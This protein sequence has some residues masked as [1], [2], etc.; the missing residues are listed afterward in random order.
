MSR[1]IRRA[2]GRYHPRYIPLRGG[3]ELCSHHTVASPDF[4]RKAHS[5]YVMPRWGGGGGG[6]GIFCTNFYFELSWKAATVVRMYLLPIS[7]FHSCCLTGFFTPIQ[8][9]RECVRS[10]YPVMNFCL[11]G[12][13]TSLTISLRDS[14]TDYGLCGFSGNRVCHPLYGQRHP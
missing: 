5:M 9:H 13:N 12:I 8:A 2:P 4:V 1:L 3:R 11:R 7:N 14:Y 6:T 10:S